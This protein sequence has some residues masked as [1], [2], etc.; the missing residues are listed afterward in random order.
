M[1]TISKRSTRFSPNGNEGFYYIPLSTSFLPPSIFSPSHFLFSGSTSN[2]VE[3]G[4]PGKPL[5]KFNEWNVQTAEEKRETRGERYIEGRKRQEQGRHRER[6]S[7]RVPEKR[8]NEFTMPGQCILMMDWI[9]AAVIN[10]GQSIR[11]DDYDDGL[12]TLITSLHIQ[13]KCPTILNSIENGK[14]VS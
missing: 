4:K 12:I 9:Q 3:G 11:N 7:N 6:K 1:V 8:E 2:T 14:I 5:D 10:V 13:Q